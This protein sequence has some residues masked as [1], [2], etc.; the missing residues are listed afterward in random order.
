MD[1]TIADKILDTKEQVYGIIYIIK[2]T[3]NQKIYIGQTVSHR[4][5]HNRYRPFGHIGRFKDHVSEAVC[6][7][8]QKQCRYLNQAIRKYGSDVFTVDVIETCSLEQL[9]DKEIHYISEYNSLY[10]HGYNLTIGGKNCYVKKIEK[11]EYTPNKNTKLRHSDTTKI[12]ISEG[13]HNYYESHPSKK[14]DLSKRV[15]N[16]HYNKKLQIG[17]KYNVDENNLDQYISIRKTSVTVLFERKRNGAKV[18]FYM[19]SNE[20]VE[21]T[22]NRAKEYLKDIIYQ[23]NILL[24]HHQ[25]A[26]NP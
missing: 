21:Y 1:D 17:L 13:I 10:P 22:I 9:N 8:K 18:N 6:N 7:T 4:K 15:Q 25:I 26:G 14:L 3:L 5:N 16:Q 12:K 2:N 19:N 23:R 20:S 24:Q 11:D